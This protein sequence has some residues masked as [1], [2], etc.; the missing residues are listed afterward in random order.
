MI[1]VASPNNGQLLENLCKVSIYKEM[2][3]ATV[4]NAINDVTKWLT[5]MIGYMVVAESYA[6]P[7]VFVLLSPEIFLILDKNS[8]CYVT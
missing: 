6:L 7:V 3:R 8:P 2:S 4:E 5:E 1:R